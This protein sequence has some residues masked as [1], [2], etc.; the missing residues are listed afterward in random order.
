MMLQTVAA[1]GPSGSSIARTNTTCLLLLPT[2]LYERRD[3]IEGGIW[4]KENAI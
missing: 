4:G 2:K 1:S 3:E